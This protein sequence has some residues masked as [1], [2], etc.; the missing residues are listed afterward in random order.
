M[1][2]SD[3]EI[4]LASALMKP[5]VWEKSIS[6]G[7]TDEFFDNSCHGDLWRT[8]KRFHDEKRR[9]SLPAIK[10]NTEK[11]AT[12]LL[13][14][15]LIEKADVLATQDI[16]RVIENVIKYKRFGQ[17]S[18]VARSLVS[19]SSLKENSSEADIGIIK[20]AINK[21]NLFGNSLTLAQTTERIE[22]DSQISSIIATF[23][24]NKK[25]CLVGSSMGL[26]STGIERL[27]RSLGGGLRPGMFYL[28]AG[29]TGSGKT[30]LACH[31][32]AMCICQG[33]KTLFFSGEM[34][35]YS[36]INRMY[37]NVCNVDVSRFDNGSLTEADQ[38]IFKAFLCESIGKNK[39]LIFDKFDRMLSKIESTIEREMRSEVKP[40]VV[41][42]DYAQM[43]IPTMR[44]KDKLRELQEISSSLKAITQR[45]DIALIALAQLNRGAEMESPELHHIMG[46]DSFAHDCDGAML[47]CAKQEWIQ[48][49][50]VIIKLRKMRHGVSSNLTVGVDYSKS[51]F[52]NLTSEREAE[53]SAQL[54]KESELRTTKRKSKNF[55]S[56]DWNSCR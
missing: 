5:K 50:F 14:D 51:K 23:E 28:L 53:I 46:N 49:G 13:I 54:E 9:Y 11:E 33:H 43:L 32:S 24:Q 3:H 45:H 41:L 30:Q 48:Q 34:K 47:I 40:K 26:P 8:M 22:S 10:A 17:I 6:I 31:I 16:D 21:I 42:I 27:D 15:K 55:N 39:L 38:E 56:I 20:E 12:K 29:R 4:L 52:I 37:A 35:D 36:I 18:D 2:L 19:L 25:L 1:S 44:Y 7:L